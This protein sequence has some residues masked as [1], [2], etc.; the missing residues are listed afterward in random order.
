MDL[1][2]S[3]VFYNPQHERFSNTESGEGGLVPGKSPN[4]PEL[5][6]L[7][8]CNGLNLLPVVRLM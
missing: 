2:D 5:M 6:L 1:H 7:S 4:I 3:N 8:D